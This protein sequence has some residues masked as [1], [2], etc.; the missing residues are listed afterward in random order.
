MFFML[1]VGVTSAWLLLALKEKE[2]INPI[3]VNKIGRN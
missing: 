3:K 2:W 1:A